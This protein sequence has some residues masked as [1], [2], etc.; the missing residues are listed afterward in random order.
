MRYYLIAG[1]PS[2]D[3]HGANLMRSLKQAD[4]QADFRYY[5]G[6]KMQ[7]EGGVLVRHYRDTAIMGFVRVLTHLPAILRNI[8]HCQQDIAAYKPDVV[9]LIDYPGFNLKIARYVKEALGLPVY[10]YIPPKIWAWKEHR[11][12]QIKKYI[13]RIYAIFPFEV[14]F[15]AKHGVE[16]VYVGNPSV[17]TVTMGKVGLPTREAFLQQNNLPDKPIIALLAGSRKQEVV[18]SLKV[19]AALNPAD[20]EGYQLVLA[21]T[22]AVSP[23]LY[24][25]VPAH[26]NVVFDQTYALL[27]HAAAGAINSGTATLETALFR[28]PQVVCYGITCSRLAMPILRRMVKIPHVSLVNIIAQKEVVKEL[29]GHHFTAASLTTELKRLLN[30]TSYRNRILCDYDALA[31]S[32]GTAIAS[33]TAA[34]DMLQGHKSKV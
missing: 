15:Y 28:L 20:F 14:G 16:A 17:Q 24:Q 23:A 2:G 29:L 18:D 27:Q 10:Y 9:I 12:H 22:S 19:Y 34:K 6:D 13:D 5:G 31:Q 26:I 7:A 1:E 25:Q 3:M 11:I 32:L 30:D 8:R 33:N 4:P 21:A